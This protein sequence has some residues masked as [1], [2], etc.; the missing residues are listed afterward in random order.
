MAFILL[1]ETTKTDS[2]DNSSSVAKQEE[3]VANVQAWGGGVFLVAVKQSFADSGFG[4][5]VGTITT[6]TSHFVTCN[7]LGLQRRQVLVA[8]NGARDGYQIYQLIVQ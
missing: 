6:V 3:A 8:Y 7:E 4:V 1:Q 5:S 2:S